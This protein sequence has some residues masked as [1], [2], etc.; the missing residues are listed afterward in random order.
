MKKW[1]ACQ[2]NIRLDKY[3]K[4]ITPYSRNQIEKLIDQEGILV[5]GKKEKASYKIKEKDEIVQIKELEINTNMEENPMDLHI[6][7]EDDSILVVD[8]PSGL[9]VHPGSGNQNHTLANALLYHTHHLSDNNGMERPG[10]VHRIDKDTSGLLLV[11]KTNEVHQILAEGFKKKTIHRSYIALLDGEFP[12]QKAIIDAP[13]GRD[14]QNRK[15]MTVI[16]TNSKNA[17]TH[18]QVMKKYVGYTLVKLTLETGRT[19]QIRVHMKYI[20]YPVHNDPV[21]TKK[22]C[23]EFGQFLHSAEMDFLHPITKEPMHFSSPLPEYFEAFLKTLEE[24]E[25]NITK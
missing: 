23:T 18:L 10:I 9:V 11:A 19:H 15:R 13:I 4:E 22:P 25:T 3:L 17:V 1:I 2:S 5:N 24:K 12:N 7:Y 16:A 14:P 21:Y 20:G 8:K 6:V